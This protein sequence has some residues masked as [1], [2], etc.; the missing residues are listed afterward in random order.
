MTWRA[1]GSE[2]CASGTLQRCCARVSAASCLAPPPHGGHAL[3]RDLCVTLF[4]QTHDNAGC[5]EYARCHAAGVLT[6]SSQPQRPAAGHVTYHDKRSFCH[7]PLLP[8]V[9][10]CL[11]RA[12][13]CASC[14]RSIHAGWSLTARAARFDAACRATPC[15]RGRTSC[16]NTSGQRAAGTPTAVW[17]CVA[18]THGRTAQRQALWQVA[19]TCGGAAGAEAGAHPHRCIAPRA[20]SHVRPW[21]AQYEPHIVPSKYARHAAAAQTLLL[22]PPLLTFGRA[23]NA[24]SAAS[25]AG[26]C[27]RT[28]RRFCATAKGSGSKRSSVRLRSLAA[29][30]ATQLC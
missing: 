7:N 26:W 14:S 15:R 10:F 2:R 11:P 20:P 5:Y 21:R 8:S 28:R 30:N 4:P 19:R 27:M 24:S 22:L 6:A 17:R 12:W 29:H 1:S 23:A 25:R 9:S 16:H 13:S 3:A 18:L